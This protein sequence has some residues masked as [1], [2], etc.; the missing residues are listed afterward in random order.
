MMKKVFT[1]PFFK[2][3]FNRLYSV[4]ISSYF[5]EGK[6]EEALKKFD[7]Y[8]IAERKYELKT[9]KSICL[10]DKIRGDCYF[11]LN[12][13]S[14]AKDI[15]NE[16]LLNFN[17]P[18]IHLNLGLT[19]ICTKEID[20]GLDELETACT[21]FRKENNTKKYRMIEQIINHLTQK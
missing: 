11:K 5:M 10:L 7:D 15:Y 19:Y 2:N 1:L 6:Y 17:D 4:L 3:L 8:N 12:N 20:K 9:P 18:N 16:I 13:F 21:I 14:K